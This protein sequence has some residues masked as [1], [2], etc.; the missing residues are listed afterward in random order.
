MSRAAVFRRIADLLRTRIQTSEYPAGGMLP[1]ESALC[2]EFGVAQTTIRRALVL[3]E[4][5]GL[6]AAI[7]AK[8]RVVKGGPATPLYRYQAIAD[9]ICDQIRQGELPPGAL[10]PSEATLCRRYAAS[11]NTV[12]QA[13]SAL[14][15]DGWINASRGGRRSVNLVDGQ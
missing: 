12:R 1:A 8:G 6:I 3:L 4:G 13:L 9:D 14:V 11:R 15:Q 5:E 2:R 10:L 7:P